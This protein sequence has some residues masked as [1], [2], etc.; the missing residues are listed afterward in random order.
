MAYEK[1]V[2]KGRTGENLD[3]YLKYDET[4]ESV[5]LVNAPDSVDE[6]VPE[7]SPENL[8]HMEE[9]IEAAHEL[10]AAERAK[11]SALETSEADIRNILLNLTGLPTWDPATHTLVFTAG[12]N[13]QLAVDLPI[14][15]LARD[16]GYDP[17]AKD[18]ILTKHDGAE[19]RISVLDLVDIYIGS[20]GAQI[21]VTVESGNIIRANLLAGSVTEDKLSYALLQKINAGGNGGGGTGAA[22]FIVDSD[23]ALE[24]WINNAPGDDFSRVFIKAGVWT[25][26]DPRTGGDEAENPL[27]AIDLSDGRT[28]SV[29]GE[30]GSKIVIHASPTGLFAGIKGAAAVD[31]VAVEVI[32]GTN[33]SCSFFECTN[34]TNCTG[35]GFYNCTNLTGSTDISADIYIDDISDFGYIYSFYACRKLTGCR[36]P[37][38]FECEELIN[39]GEGSDSVFYGCRKLTNC[40]G[41]GKGGNKIGRGFCGFVKCE[42]LIGC[43]GA[44]VGGDKGPLDGRGAAFSSCRK[45]I[46]CR[47]AATDPHTY[48]ITF[49]FWGCEELIGCAGAG[50]GNQNSSGFG[51]CTNLIYCDARSDGHDYGFYECRTGF[52]CKGSGR[53]AP[54]VDCYMEE[55]AEAVLLTP[56]DATALGG[57]NGDQIINSMGGAPARHTHNASDIAAGALPV[58]RGGTGATTAAAARS[59]LD[60]AQ[61]GHTHNASQ[62]GGLP[63]YSL[64]GTTLNISF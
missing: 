48:S 57:Y 44:G 42:E 54:F 10:I 52:G 46:N 2:W 55:A 4:A 33:R 26:N 59:A 40:A 43:V 20:I 37:R 56:W 24:A 39:C 51:F 18:I 19:I 63:T 11:V 21:Q 23:A 9:G 25:Y 36:G 50:G 31:N 16:V 49:G 64:S 35:K 12:D 8:N 6:A 41:A 62:I 32:A 45:L 30:N 15:S 29:A 38:F 53:T 28:L 34:L 27:A 22:A 14:E 3:K 58:A 47:G 13:S 61:A 7:L 5:V 17:D 1:T 60:A